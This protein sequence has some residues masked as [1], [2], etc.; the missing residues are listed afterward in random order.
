MPIERQ[1]DAAAK[2]LTKVMEALGW[3]RPAKPIR[4]G[5]RTCRAFTFVEVVEDADGK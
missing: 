3:Q 4:I 2:R 1:T 5:K